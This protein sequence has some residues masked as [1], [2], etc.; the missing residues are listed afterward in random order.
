MLDSK[1]I[2]QLHDTAAPAN[3]GTKASMLAELARSGETV[4]AGF[5]IPVQIARSLDADDLA[6]SIEAGLI[7]MGTGRV[8][9]RSSGL[10]EDLENEAHA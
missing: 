3:A 4:P 9:V 10:G 1:T 6:P 8:A 7:E 5:V 2:Q